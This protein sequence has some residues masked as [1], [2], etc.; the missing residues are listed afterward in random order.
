MG[1]AVIAA[2]VSPVQRLRVY[3]AR[4]HQLVGWAGVLGVALLVVA[5]CVTALAWSTHSASL[6]SADMR[7]ATAVG[8]AAKPA[9]SATQDDVQPVVSDLPRMADVPLLLTQM[10][11]AALSNGLAWRAA[12]YRI[13]AATLNRPATLEVRSSLKGPYPKLR[14]MLVQLMMD[15][16]AFTI[17]EFSASRPNTDTADVET[18]LLL[19]VFLRDD[20]SLSDSSLQKATP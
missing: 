3:A 8:S 13:T 14:S 5:I 19:S 4:V 1:R 16:P 18:K 20:A 9:K 11:Q 12:D 7:N 10:E 15:V 6:R 17:R 2:S